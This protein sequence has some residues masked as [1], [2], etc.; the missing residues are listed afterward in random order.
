MVRQEK[1]K[2]VGFLH[3]LLIPTTVSVLCW[4]GIDGKELQN[5]RHKRATQSA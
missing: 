5:F 4:F 3:T 2:I 1:E